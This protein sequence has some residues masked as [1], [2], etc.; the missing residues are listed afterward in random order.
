MEVLAGD[1]YQDA[2][3]KG[4][5]HLEAH[6]RFVPDHVSSSASPSVWNV[7]SLAQQGQALKIE[8]QPLR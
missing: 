2:I 6:D 1:S 3:W 7:H 4:F 5:K 8:F